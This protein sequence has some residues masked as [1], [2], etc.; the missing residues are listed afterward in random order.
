LDEFD[1]IAKV[2]RPLTFGAP[3]ALDLMDDAA[4]IAGRP[5]F[6][7]VITKDAM[8]EGVHFLSHDPLDLT[9]RKLLRVNLSDLAAKGATPCGYFLAIAW[10]PGSSEAQRR[11]F[12]DG[13]RVEQVAHGFPLLGG[14][15]VSTPG[16]LTASVT[17][18][19]WVEAGR[20]VKRSGACAGD[21]VLV[22][23]VIGDAGLG[24]RAARGEFDALGAD[25]V[26]YLADRYRL[27]SPRL[28]LSAALLGHASAAADVSDGLLADAGHIGEA[29]GLGLVIDL[30]RLPISPAAQLWLA[31]Q[32]DPIAAY[33]ALATFGD[34]Y[35]VVCT[36]APASL[37][38][39]LAAATEAGT[40]L[41]PIGEAR[42]GR[43]VSARWRDMEIAVERTGW[44]HP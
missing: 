31:Q 7:L 2:F 10:P 20:M 41:T 28:A 15:T 23:G 25:A 35:E 1:Q 3:E 26:A 16:P 33:A 4:V 39:L 37:D 8:V 24:L 40:P 44:R 19:G 17:L 18:L 27:P 42:A 30:E 12:A 32:P 21:I 29:S 22:S 11:L 38:A 6:D 5:G 9:A 36:A 14:D 13:L 34:D 43:G